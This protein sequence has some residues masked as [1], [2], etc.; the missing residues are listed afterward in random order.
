[1]KC[2]TMLVQKLKMN[3]L[4]TYSTENIEYGKTFN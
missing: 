2:Y 4:K 1:M 3:Y